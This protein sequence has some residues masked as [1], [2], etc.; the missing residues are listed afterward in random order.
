LKVFGVSVIVIW[1]E[2]LKE[3]VTFYKT[4]GLPLEEEHH[5]EGP[6]HYACEIGASHFAIFEA[7]GGDAIRRNN[8]GCTQIGFQVSSVEDAFAAS[9][10]LGASVVW[11]PRNMPWGKAALVC[12]PDGRPVELNE[13][14]AS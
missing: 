5:G 12:D 11:E 9:Q 13:P 10:K 3:M 2:R 14:A 7:T 8:G 4:L 6:I 1:T